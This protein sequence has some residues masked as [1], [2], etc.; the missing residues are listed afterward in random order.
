MERKEKQPSISLEALPNELLLHTFSYLTPTTIERLAK[1]FNK[2]LTYLCL[3][4]LKD[5]LAA[6]QNAKR[7]TALF[8]YE[9]PPHNLKDALSRNM[10]DIW[11]HYRLKRKWGSFS[12][13]PPFTERN[14]F[15]CLDFLNL[16]GEF[17]WL[18]PI[19]D[20]LDEDCQPFEH[21]RNFL[22]A[23]DVTTLKNQAQQL[24]LEFPKGFFDFMRTMEKDYHVRAPG[25]NYFNIRKG[26]LT[27]VKYRLI[28]VKAAQSAPESAQTATESAQSIPEETSNAAGSA[29]SAPNGDTS[30]QYNMQQWAFVE[31][32]VLRFYSDQQGCGSW[33][34]FLHPGSPPKGDPAFL[35]GPGHCVLGSCADL[36]YDAEPGEESPA[37]TLTPLEEALGIKRTA[38]WDETD[39]TFEG[40]SF[41]EFV[42]R[43]YF[44]TMA[45]IFEPGKGA[46]LPEEL[47]KY[48]V[49]IYSEKG[50]KMVDGIDL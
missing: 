17:D 41:E 10:I 42:A 22:S 37:V 25:G 33:N 18:A 21:C 50:R 8:A 36:A 29:Q 11:S 13:P 31:G 1:A 15:P 5:R 6:H 47:K 45:V 35:S 46:R 3:P 26:G 32:Y 7:M 19:D 24:G 9:P 23:E 49:G 16:R 48:M 4:L 40:T 2:R 28:G 12:S 43:K 14:P 27:K 30:G 44:D 39:W 34:L 20:L 38:F